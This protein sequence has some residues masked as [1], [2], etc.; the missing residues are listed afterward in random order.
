MGGSRGSIAPGSAAWEFEARWTRFS[1]LCKGGNLRVRHSPKLSREVRF[2][3]DV[4]YWHWLLIEAEP[5]ITTFCEEPVPRD[6]L[7][8]KMLPLADVWLKRSDGTIEFRSV[9]RSDRQVSSTERVLEETFGDGF[10]Y[11][12]LSK[13]EVLSEPFLL[14]NSLRMVGFLSSSGPAISIDLI[15]WIEEAFLANRIQSLGEMVDRLAPTY[16]QERALVALFGLIQ[17]GRVRANLSE[18]ITEATKLSWEA[19][20]NAT[21]AP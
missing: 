8:A 10:T 15:F 18:R 6:R 3:R 5:E 21:I 13:E 2:V 11:R 7:D 17:Q 19:A 1:G 20:G 16:G 12:A 9:A 14:D 4:D